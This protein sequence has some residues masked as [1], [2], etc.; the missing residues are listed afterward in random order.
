M[1]FRCSLEHPESTL[2]SRMHEGGM[3][4]K[5]KATNL[6]ALWRLWHGIGGLI[7]WHWR[8]TRLREEAISAE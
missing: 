8:L 6:W 5:A 4:H 7:V 1:S 3:Q 2:I